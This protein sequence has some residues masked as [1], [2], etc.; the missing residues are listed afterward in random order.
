V[1]ESFQEKTE[2]ATPRR[3]E[4]A[5]TKGQ[6][7]RSPELTTAFL[8]LASGG[9]IAATGPGAAHAF[10]EI[11]GEGFMRAAAPPM[12]ID[13]VSAWLRDLTVRAA[14]ATAPLVLGLAAVGASVAAM[15]ARGVLTLHP[16]K[17]DWARVSPLKNAGRI[18][19]V[20]ALVELTKSILKMLVVG[21]AMYVSMRRAW[22]EFTA[23]GQQSPLALARALGHY[24]VVVMVTAGGAYL[25]IA[26]IDFAYQL[27]SHEKQLRMTKE[28]VKR[29]HKEMEGDP[30]VKSRLRTLGRAMIRRQMFRDVAKADVVVTNPTHIAVALKYD[31]SVS[32]APIVLA[33]GQRKIAE[34]I[35]RLAFEAGVPVIENKP[36]ARALLAAGRIGLPIPA[37]L[38]VAVAEVLAF[39]FRRRAATA[40]SWKGSATL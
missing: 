26:G 16:L 24:V 1:A 33:V 38:Y 7:A 20:R 14:L 36:L 30:L 25:L 15:Q 39:V 6:V 5:K 31:P 19:G 12:N 23:L 10:A 27:W 32:P 17:P 9:L 40:R 3:R 21:V 28:E 2:A 29:E 8:L 11:L 18:W 37:E 13:G 35:K 4:E 22:P 34:R